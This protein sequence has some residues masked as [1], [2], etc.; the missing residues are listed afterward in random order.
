MIEPAAAGL[1]IYH[2]VFRKRGARLCMLV[3]VFP[4]QLF[5]P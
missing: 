1:L 2:V 5:N 4:F 3:S